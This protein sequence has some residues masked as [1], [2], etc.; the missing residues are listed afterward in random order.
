M[1]LQQVTVCQDVM[2][3]YMT[4]DMPT[5]V[6]QEQQPG[7]D[8]TS[9]Q[10]QVLL[11]SMQSSSVNADLGSVPGMVI[12]D[13]SN[14][15]V[16]GPLSLSQMGMT[17]QGTDHSTSMPMI[18]QLQVP[19]S[20]QCVQQNLAGPDISVQ[21]VQHMQPV[22]ATLQ[23]QQVV[24]VNGPAVNGTMQPQLAA[25]AGTVVPDSNGSAVQMQLQQL[26][27]AVQQLSSQTAAV[28]QMLL[29]AQHSQ[30]PTNT[31]NGYVQVSRITVYQY[32]PHARSTLLDCPV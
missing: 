2:G 9:A 15:G 19:A 5:Q 23:G 25:C 24:L 14:S 8:L 31:N 4:L 26:Q 21:H 11:D 22:Y 30:E 7:V 13:S 20:N 18:I 27:D 32:Y 12:V 6:L 16:S 1:Q 3:Q 10:I 28:Q 17:M 29:T